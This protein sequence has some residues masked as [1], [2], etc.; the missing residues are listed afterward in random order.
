MPVEK[1]NLASLALNTTRICPA[2]NVDTAAYVKGTNL[3]VLA[4]GNALRDL[5]CNREKGIALT[6]YRTSGCEGAK[7]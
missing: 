5:C 7:G 6:S 4:R 3:E 2:V 1:N